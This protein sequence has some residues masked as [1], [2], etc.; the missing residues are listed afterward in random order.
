MT[1]VIDERVVEM[2]FNNADF[3]KN[4]A[5]SMNTLDNL[6]KALDFD[7]AK[8]L[9]NIGKAS[10]NFSLSGVT[11]T[12]TEATQKFSALEIA[13]IT[14]IMNI[15][16]KAVDFG[17]NFAKSLSIDQVTSGFDKYATKTQA[18]QTIMS[19]TSDQFAD[20]AEQMAY[21]N[22]QLE[23]LTWFT[24]ETSYNMIDMTSNIGKF[25]SN[26]IALDKAVT[27]MEGIATWAGL[28]GAGTQEASRAMYNF[29]QA[30][31]AGAMKLQDWKSIENANMATTK[32]KQTAIDT[33]VELGKLEK[34]ADGVVTT[35]NGKTEVSITSFSESLKQKWFDTDV[36]TETLGKFG[37][38]ADELYK[39][40]DSTGLTASELLEAL[41]E[42]KAG[43]LDVS[44]IARECEMSVTDLNAEFSRLSGEGFE[45]GKKAFAASQ[46]AKTFK[47][48]IDSVKDAVSSGW[49]NTFE[50][51]FGNYLEAKKLWTGLANNLYDMFA[52]GGNKRNEVLAVWK[53]LGGRNSLIMGAVNALNLLIKPFEAIKKAFESILPK[54]KEFG[55]ILNQLTYKFYIFTSR[56]Q[57]SQELL[58]NLYQL[59]RGL[60]SIGKVVLSFFGQLISAIVKIVSP[61][62]SVIEVI[63]NILGKVGI[64]LQIISV[65]ITQSGVIQTVISF[66]VM[67]LEKLIS[68]VK[69]VAVIFAGGLFVGIKAFIG[70]IQKAIVV[71]TN[72]VQTAGSKLSGVGNKISS[73]F[74]KVTGIFSKFN[75]SGKDTN[76]VVK[77]MEK[78]YGSAAGAVSKFGT[79]SKTTGDQVK[80]NM[81]LFEKFLDILNK[82]KGVMVTFATVIGA[83]IVALGTKIFKFFTDFKARY[84]DIT[85]NATSFKDYFVAIFQTIGS[86][87]AEGWEKVKDFFA[88][89]NIDIS[90]LQT[91][92]TTIKDGIGGIIDKLG[93]GRIAALG[94]A[95]A[96]LAL[97]G[98][99]IKL[100]DSF[101]SMFGAVTDVFNNINK[102]LKKQ[103]AKS[104]V[105]TDLAKAFAILAGSLALL[106]F[107][108]QDDL[109]RVAKVMLKLMIAFTVCA[110]AL[111]ALDLVLSKF[112]IETDFNLINSNIMALAASMTLLTLAFSVLNTIELKDDWLKK[113]GIMGIMLIEVVAAAAVLSKVAPQLS[114]GSIL[115]LALALSMKLMVDALAKIGEKDIDGVNKNLAGFTVLFIGVAAMV[116]AAGKIKLT[117]ALSLILVAK[118]LNYLLPVIGDV[119]AQVQPYLTEMYD[120]LEKISIDFTKVKTM[121][122]QAFDNANAFFEYLFS[123]L[124]E[125]HATIIS[126]FTIA[127]T[128]LLSIAGLAAVIAGGFAIA[129]II[130]A[131]GTLGNLIK[132]IGIAIIGL[133]IGIKLVAGT[134]IELGEY[135]KYLTNKQYNRIIEGFTAIAFIMTAA[136]GIVTIIDA[137]ATLFTSNAI[138]DGKHVRTSF[139]GIAA[140]FVGIG[141]A[142]R[143][144]V[145]SL[146][147]LEGLK[148][149]TFWPVIGAM[150]ALLFCLGLAAA[151]AGMI[152]KGGSAFVGLIG[153]AA[154]MA[155][156]VAELGIISA[157]W[158]DDNTKGMT[159]AVSA[160]IILFTG[161]TAMIW[162]LS[163]IQKAGPILALTLPIFGMILTLAGMIVLL[164]AMKDVNYTAIGVAVGGIATVLVMVGALFT[165]IANMPALGTALKSKMKLLRTVLG[166]V[167]AVAGIIAVLGAETYF[168][169]GSMIGAIVALGL[170]VAALGILFSRIAKMPALGTGLDSKLKLLKACVLAM[171]GVAIP[172][173]AL[174][175]ACK[176]F[177]WSMAGSIV[178][179]GLGM[180]ALGGLMT[181]IA[182]MPAVGSG[183]KNK[184]VLLAAC[185]IAMGGVAYALYELSK[186]DPNDNWNSLFVLALGMTAL[187]VFL[188]AMIKVTKGANLKAI[189]GTRGLILATCVFIFTLA[190]SIEMLT[191]LDPDRLSAAATAITALMLPIGALAAVMGIIQGV[192]VGI[193]GFF[194]L[195]AGTWAGAVALPL[196]LVAMGTAMISMSFGFKI[197]AEG[198]DILVN[199]ATKF[200][201]VLK[202]IADLPLKELITNLT[203]L[204]MPLVKAGIAFGIF[205][206]GGGIGG[207]GIIILAKGLMLLN[208]TLEPFATNM[209]TLSTIDFGSVA[210]GMVELAVAGFVM[211][212][213]ASSVGAFALALGGLA[214]AVGAYS[215]ASGGGG[216][217]PKGVTFEP[218]ATDYQ[219]TADGM[220]ETSE[221]VKK[222]MVENNA[223]MVVEC[224]SGTLTK[225]EDLKKAQ[226]E[227]FV[228]D[229][230]IVAKAESSAEAVKDAQY[231][232][233][234]EAVSPE[235]AAHLEAQYAD[236]GYKSVDAYIDAIERGEAVRDFEIKDMHTQLIEGAYEDAKD[237][238]VAKTKETLDAMGIET[239]NGLDGV[240]SS[241]WNWVSDLAPEVKNWGGQLGKIFAGNWA[242]NAMQIISKMKGSFEWMF[243]DAIKN[244]Q[245]E[246]LS[247]YGANGMT[248]EAMNYLYN[249][250]GANAYS[251]SLTALAKAG[252]NA[253][254][255]AGWSI[256]EFLGVDG[257]LGNVT[258]TIEDATKGL[259]GLTEAGGKAGKGMKELASSLRDTISNQLDIFSK[260]ELKTEVS[261]DQMLENMRS[262]I[263]GFASW[264][265]RITV[266]AERGID[267]GLLQKL[268]ELGPKG[269]ET[270]NAFYQMTDE[271]LQEANDLF[272]TSLTLPDSQT[273]IVMSA[274]QYAG[275]MAIQGFSNALDDHRALHESIHGI[276]TD[277]EKDLADEF[278][279]HSPSKLM[280]RQGLNVMDGFNLGLQ[281]RL[282]YIEGTV[283]T[284]CETTRELFETNLDPSTFEG[285]GGDFLTNLFSAMLT[286][287]EEDEG[288]NPILTAFITSLEELDEF[289]EAIEAFVLHFIELLNELFEMD[290][291][292]SPSQLFARYVDGWL[293]GIMEALIDEERLEILNNSLIAFCDM[294]M[295]FIDSYDLPGKFFDIGVNAAQGL[296]DGINAGAGA[297]IAAAQALADQVKAILKSAF[298]E[299]SPSK[300]TRK[301]G[302]YVSEGLALGIKDGAQSVYD[303]A[304]S[305]AQ[306]GIDGSNDGMGRLQ[307]VLNSG[308]DL[309]PIITPMLDLSL[310]R[311]QV[312]EL[313]TMM[314]DPT[315]GLS[316]QNGGQFTANPETQ[317]INFTQNNYSPKALSRMEI[318]RQ[319]KNQLSMMKGVVAN[320]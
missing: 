148:E 31:G 12:I 6:K 80:K 300:V 295:F 61:A 232:I 245:G 221:T 215:N 66:I 191:E 109:E 112:N 128:V 224:T 47:E 192:L 100:S 151:G 214:A 316:G 278:E 154:S 298:D 41:D 243:S 180:T 179:L 218:I 305:L 189:L 136:I 45:L 194:G 114:K 236:L 79:V 68:V 138:Y 309:N 14:A 126:C 137:L 37:N 212:S 97:V 253:G 158:T 110:G 271:Q 303:A 242:Y 195:G 244:A 182:K 280:F 36:M 132:G 196:L 144:I 130:K 90:S 251:K 313:S 281:S 149:E 70:L 57:P 18:V 198:I 2:R 228:I 17:L 24:D 318:Y 296:A 10:K 257:A 211:G 204:A 35:L 176:A 88:Q 186:Q 34:S 145:A 26:N 178:T 65:F 71:V 101:G 25:V 67:G 291:Q 133:A 184:I 59:F 223:E 106:T 311:S 270:M 292:E 140:A 103:F 30:M 290:D 319:T 50:I 164:G 169:G 32:F 310:I 269:Y 121:A 49:M 147:G 193:G 285:I 304:N 252:K 63:G 217:G 238:A 62:K 7:S 273:D 16:N 279:M 172:L 119:L 170:G 289:D 123:T 235:E 82:A 60:F 15:T 51:I 307:D 284:I 86:L 38:F 1:T 107:V 84:Q 75:K 247:R 206:V 69:N 168:V 21:V 312:D 229:D 120:R 78:N 87:F 274:Y 200:V 160:M 190:K 294:V 134:I 268:M 105:V 277:S 113:L 220:V 225:G 94:F 301:I 166:S 8:S 241:I 5:Q 3:E 129:A 99:A 288:Q 53:E 146:K 234:G 135:F 267:Q 43:T 259:D 283:T 165:Y 23:K 286:G 246:A 315:Y 39:L 183:L 92:F 222:K 159:R 161:L 293:S 81:T 29:S 122:K 58:N 174:A 216:G 77:G 299:H 124:S 210:A 201:P 4:V 54:G 227:V 27:A 256:T 117:S 199:A 111:R 104:S 250:K 93:P 197:A 282:S 213:A 237:T 177:G 266:L 181:Y 98:A 139:M 85:K 40:S 260:F 163:Q 205:G 143:L 157:M 230:D 150:S 202:E 48:A 249:S 11:E 131:I 203:G 118:A 73:A 162:S 108:N 275:E 55:K 320:A 152:T 64:F 239:E 207:L 115:L 167:A 28:S 248:Q 261:A 83:G 173:V 254:D 188:T 255:I 308:I 233:F 46:E 187:G 208:P 185:V 155:L 56:I 127:G 263:D 52:E 9:E 171:I 287:G 76:T 219:K 91:A 231:K 226:E 72:F 96:M 297:A 272:A 314:S 42:Y 306:S 142:M 317:Q 153:I 262:N 209:Q 22:E 265:H 44:E 116:A 276:R 264:S 89:F 95:T 240:A 13:G 258:K 20:Q 141:I 102:I 302:L 125:T 74:S 19:A 175:A 33:A 156:L